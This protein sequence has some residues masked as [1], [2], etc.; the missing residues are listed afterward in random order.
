MNKLLLICLFLF[1]CGVKKKPIA[2]AENQLPSII[3]RYQKDK[4]KKEDEVES[5]S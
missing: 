4:E 2:P 5:E 3:D 1:S